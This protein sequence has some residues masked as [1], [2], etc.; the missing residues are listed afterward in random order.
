MSRPIAGEY[1]YDH[2]SHEQRD[3]RIL[4]DAG[5]LEKFR[6]LFDY[7]PYLAM[8]IK[9]VRAILEQR[10]ITTEM[11]REVTKQSR[12][13]IRRTT[14]FD[15]VAIP[16][17]VVGTNLCHPD[18]AHARLD[19][20]EQAITVITDRLGGVYTMCGCPPASILYLIDTL[21]TAAQRG[22]LRER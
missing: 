14:R 18:A 3:A 15:A 16:P 11:I 21:E 5:I 9:N 19:K 12:E 8:R 2:E 7:D 20:I 4:Y 17:K 13:T 10:L 1:T 22:E 6:T